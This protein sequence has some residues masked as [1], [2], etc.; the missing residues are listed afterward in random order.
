MRAALRQNGAHGGLGSA[1]G[2][3]DRIE[4]PIRAGAL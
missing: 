2:D 1:I 3:G 4:I